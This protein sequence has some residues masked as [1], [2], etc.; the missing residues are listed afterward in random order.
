MPRR[1]RWIL[2]PR[3]L[4]ICRRFVRREMLVARPDK[5]VTHG[6]NPVGVDEVGRMMT[7]GRRWGANL[8]LGDKIPLGFAGSARRDRRPAGPGVQFG[9][10]L[11]T[12]A[13][14]NSEAAGLGRR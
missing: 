9:R 2:E 6:H 5:G 13:S 3:W 10:W 7:Q 12:A 8:G 11:P 14:D 1:G 4:E